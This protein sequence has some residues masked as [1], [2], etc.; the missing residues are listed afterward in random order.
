MIILD[1]VSLSLKGPH[2]QLSILNHIFLKVNAGEKISIVGPSG[3]GKTSLLMVMA[4]LERVS[5]GTILI[6]GKQVSG[7][8]EDEM[9]AFRRDTIG[10]VFQ[11][12]HLIPTMTALENVAVPMEFAGRHDAMQA[13]KEALESVGLGQRMAHLPA[14]LSGASS[15]AWSW[16]ALLPCARKS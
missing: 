6:N 9:A 1:D 16:R 11:N 15:S 7:L 3:S 13:A 4:G 14:Q 10:I 8:N 12:F 2:G 5:S